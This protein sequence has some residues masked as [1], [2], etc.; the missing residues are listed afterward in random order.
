MR[1]AEF[2]G[3]GKCDIVEA[4]DPKVA[5]NYARIKIYSAP[6]CTEFKGFTGGRGKGTFGHEAAGEV[7]AI[8]DRVTHVGVGDRVV[9]MPQNGCGTCELCTAGD[10]IHCRSLRDP[11]Q[12]CGSETGI[13]RVAQYCIQQDWLLVRIP[14]ELSFDYA[15]M[16]CCGFGPAFNAMQAMNVTAGDTVLVSGLGPVGL[17][18]V[19]IALYRGA[20]VLGLD[21]SGHRRKLASGLGAQETFDPD[22][23]NVNTAIA[24]ATGGVQFSVE[25]SGA[26]S[27]PQFLADVARPRGQIA[28]IGWGGPIEARTIIGKG[29]DIHGCWHWNHQ[30][31]REGMLNTIA[32]SG[33][34]IDK[35]ITH[36]FPLSRIEDAMALQISGLCGKVIVHPWDD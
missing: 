4:D 17:G 27:A 2:N 6:L 7:V 14:P 19:T 15:V 13:G 29:L 23:E 8:G 31:D 16:A 32:G 22:E 33:K 26:R 24:A 21:M 34:L 35:L 1:Q 11:L 3:P 5:D 18:A 20:R 25:T 30:R 9:V 28:L 36:T 12:V 10:H